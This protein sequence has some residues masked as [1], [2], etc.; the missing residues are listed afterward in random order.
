VSRPAP[1]DLRGVL[2]AFALLLAAAAPGV[3]AACKLVRLV[4]IRVSM[5]GLVPLVHA[6]INGADSDSS[7]LDL[8][9]ARRVWVSHQA[10]PAAFA[11][12]MRNPSRLA[13]AAHHNIHSNLS[14][15]AP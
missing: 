11:Y 7:I 6:K 13:C 5:S 1:Y 15:V 4:E 9:T 10:V 12:K 2:T 14:T 8:R 3:C